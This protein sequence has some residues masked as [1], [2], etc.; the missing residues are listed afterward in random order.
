MTAHDPA[1]RRPIARGV[2]ADLLARHDR[3]G[4]R[5]TSYPT[6]VEF[7]EGITPAAY[8]A[9]LAEADRLGDAPL[10]VY[11]HLP[12]C[13]QRCLFCGCHVIITPHREVAAPYLDLLAREV[14]MVA[15]RLPHRRRFAQLHLGG[16]TPT[17]YTPDQL[18]AFLGRF[19]ERF[20]PLPGAELALEADPRVTTAA[21]LEALAALGF[22]RIS[23][24]VQDLTP[25]VQQAINRVQSLEQTAALVRRAR[26]LG[27]RGINVD[28]IYGLP[29]Q[30]PETFERTVASVIDLG[31]DRAAVYSFAFVPWIRGHQKKLME[32]SLPSPETK[33]TLFALARE[34]FL[35]AGYEPIGMDHF[36]RPDDELARAR[37]EGRLRRNFQGY[38]VI[39]GDD[40][41]GFG[42]SAIGDVRGA[43]VQNEKKLSTYE[44]AVQAG[45]LPVARGVARSAD[46]EVRRTVIHELM[47]NFRLDT[48]DIGRRYGVEFDRYFADDLAL[49][50]AYERE[51]FVRLA[52]GRIEATPTGELFVRNLA[53]C[54]DRYMREKHAADDRP[55]FSRTV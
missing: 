24:G 1:A 23:F 32:D 35:E 17:Y 51:G 50:R 27:F 13:E 43:Y 48:A 47:C 18:T 7:G 22:N 20:E 6:A 2:T 33:L 19:L 54:F 41:I 21:H 42:I 15:E 53:M 5:Y 55:T 31:V 49:L 38:A 9:R 8:E 36:A 37:R 26:E 3:P 28:L 39:P 30:T 11:V 44:E 34:R 14:E 45:R 29:L 12:F 52:P 25:D 46:D 4:P 10:A 16:G 40:V